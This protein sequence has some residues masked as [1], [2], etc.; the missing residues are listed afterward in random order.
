MSVWMFSDPIRLPVY[1]LWNQPLRFLLCPER[2][3]FIF[4][5]FVQK[6]HKE[7]PFLSGTI[8]VQSGRNERTSRRMPMQAMK[9]AHLGRKPM[10]R[11]PLKKH[12]PP[13]MR[14]NS[15]CGGQTTNHLLTTANVWEFSYDRQRR[16]LLLS[17]AL[18]VFAFFGRM[19]HKT[20]G[21]GRGSCALYG[22]RADERQFRIR[23]CGACFPAGRPA[24]PARCSGGRAGGAVRPRQS[25]FLPQKA[26]RSV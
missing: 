13:R 17:T 3:I 16:F 11:P 24:C 6:P 4:F 15:Q 12:C 26:V 8:R 20:P 10:L 14:G 5:Q 22:V 7:T 19:Q 21:A 23:A 9:T 25:R 18:P 1:L 2:L